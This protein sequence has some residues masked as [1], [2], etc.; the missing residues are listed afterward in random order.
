MGALCDAAHGAAQGSPAQRA[1]SP[2]RQ[3]VESTSEGCRSPLHVADVHLSMPYGLTRMVQRSASSGRTRPASKVKTIR[4]ALPAS[5]VCSSLRRSV[6]CRGPR[7]ARARAATVE[8]ADTILARIARAG[9]RLNWARHIRRRVR[10]RDLR[11]AVRSQ[12]ARRAPGRCAAPC[13]R[14]DLKV[15]RICRR[16]S[17]GRLSCSGT[18]QPAGHMLEPR[19]AARSR[20]CAKTRKT[21]RLRARARWRA[22]ALAADEDVHSA[23]C[24]AARCRTAREHRAASSHPA[25]KAARP[26]A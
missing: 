6:G 1:P 19:Q 20:G 23:S 17:M 10:D 7:R 5:T 12:F 2:V 24:K 18:A 21:S 8:P 3:S 13:R 14:Q 16:S 26:A 15:R 25:R 22:T 11:Q 4:G 9:D